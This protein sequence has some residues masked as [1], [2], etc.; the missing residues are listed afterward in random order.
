MFCKSHATSQA[1][2]QTLGLPNTFASAEC[3][4]ICN[5]QLMQIQV[6]WI[7]LGQCHRIEAKEISDKK[8]VSNDPMEDKN[9]LFRQQ[10]AIISKKML[11]PYDVA[12][13]LQLRRETFR[14][15]CRLEPVASPPIG[16]HPSV[17]GP[18]S[19]TGSHGH[20]QV[21]FFITSLP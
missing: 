7:V 12:R 21:S 5:D 14:S 2:S 11:A 13:R 1:Q 4:C 6:L 19:T 8:N 10:A 18:P 20:Y 17:L 9:S 16:C 15:T 3:L